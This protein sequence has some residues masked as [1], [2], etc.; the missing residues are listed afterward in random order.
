V[1][2][3]RVWSRVSPVGPWALTGVAVA[4]FGG[5]LALAALIVVV[6]PF[7]LIDPKGFYSSLIKP[8]LAALW[9]S[10]LIVFLVYLRF[11]RSHRQRALPAWSLTIV[12]S[13]CALSGL[14]MT[15]HQTAS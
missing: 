1:T 15:F 8:S 2:P 12:A 3:A 14:W 6:A 5:P 13:A 4:S 7:T 10:Q 11:A 9:V